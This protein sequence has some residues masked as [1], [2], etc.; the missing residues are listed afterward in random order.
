GMAL[1][2]GR[3]RPRMGFRA[4]VAVV[5]GAMAGSLE[6]V[7]EAVVRFGGVGARLHQAGSQNATR[8]TFALPKF[9]RA[10]NGPTL[11]RPCTGHRLLAMGAAWWLVVVVLV[12]IG[13]RMARGRDRAAAVVIPVAAAVTMASGYVFFVPYAAPRFLLPAYALIAV[14]AA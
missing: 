5:I 6:W 1:A 9:A 13:V 8:L 2:M 4:A 11:C 10:V 7:I 14:P 12:V 3:R